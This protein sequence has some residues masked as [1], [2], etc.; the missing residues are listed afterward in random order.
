MV[1]GR[2]ETPTMILTSKLCLFPLFYP[3]SESSDPPQF[4]NNSGV[5]IVATCQITK[6]C[7]LQ[8]YINVASLEF[9]QAVYIRSIWEITMK[10]VS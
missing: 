1:N 3:A 9:V 4:G 8:Q 5:S 2:P 7:L 6:K 10:I